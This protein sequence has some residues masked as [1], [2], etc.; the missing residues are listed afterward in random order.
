M[1]LMGEPD[2]ATK[3]AAKESRTPKPLAPWQLPSL[4]WLFVLFTAGTCIDVAT[5]L[6]ARTGLDNQMET[7]QTEITE[8]EARV[9]QICE[10]QKSREV[11]R[12]E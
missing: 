2:N 11:T 9:N 1:T 8:L 4:Y 10:K 5:R 3:S 12:P 7:L 6:I